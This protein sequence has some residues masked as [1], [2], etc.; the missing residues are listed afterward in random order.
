MALPPLLLAAHGDG[1]RRWAEV[2][3]RSRQVELLAAI[4]L[5]A[6]GVEGI[7]EVLAARPDAAIAVWAAG[8]REAARVAEHLKAHPGPAL[9]HP[10]PA[11]PPPGDHLQLV[12]GWLTLSG[13]GALER[14]FSSRGVESVRLEVRGLPEGAAPGITEALQHAMTVVRRFGRD[15]A[16]ES[17][18]LATEHELSVELTVDGRPWHVKVAVRGRE[19]DLVVRTREGEYGWASDGVSETLRRPRAEPRAIPALPWEE[20]CLRQITHP[21]KGCTLADAREVTRLVDEVELQLGR[22]LPPDHVIPRGSGLAAL[23]LRGEVPDAAPLAPT[24]PPTPTLRPSTSLGFDA[25]AYMHGLLPAVR[26][27]VA[28]QDEAKVREALPGTVLRRERRPDAGP[29]GEPRVTLCAAREPEAA[30]ALARLQEPTSTDALTRLGALLGHPAC[31]V[32]AFAA[33]VDRADASFNRLAVAT[34]TSAGPGPWPAVL[35]DTALRLLPH[36]PCTYRC[37]RSKERA[38]ALLRVLADEAPAL[39]TRV[40]DYLGGPVL[41]FDQGRQLRF[42]GHVDAMAIRYEAVFLPWHADDAFARLAGAVAQGDRLVLGADHL[43]VY[44][45]GERLFSLD[46]TDPGL[47]LV[48]PFGAFAT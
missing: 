35:D 7:E 46:R 12:H 15:V 38:M 26:V 27:T 10:P 43:S 16:V 31:C 33:Q 29:P 48:F 47:G 24:A 28:P 6:G 30:R 19:L 25:L 37:E 5:A 44:A 39:H 23:G 1:A 22:R 17:A 36:F 45:A 13:V 2:A 9:L 20:R 41:Y 40:S 32:Q 42:R 3:K 11:R 21:V 8:P 14:L 18:V 34:R 4:D